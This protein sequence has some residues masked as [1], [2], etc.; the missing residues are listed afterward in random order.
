M[1]RWVYF[2]I[3]HLLH[4]SECYG[5]IFHK[6]ANLFSQSQRR[7]KIKP[8]SEISCHNT[9]TSVISGLFHARYLHYCS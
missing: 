5:E 1:Y 9:L 6:Q 8:E 4:L 7:V 2:G 3:N